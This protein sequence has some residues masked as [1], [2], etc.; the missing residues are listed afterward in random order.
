MLR[1][2]LLRIED[3]N[4]RGGKPLLA[5]HAWTNGPMMYLVYTAPPSDIT[6]GLVRDTRESIIDPVPWPDVDEAVRWYYYLDLDEGQPWAFFREPGEPDTIRWCG[7]PL[8]DDL[9]QR[10]SDIPDAYRYTSPPRTSSTTRDQGQ[11]QRVVNEPRRY[12]DPR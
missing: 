4:S 3:E 8:E 5:S 2:L 11:D 10:L 9:P 7:Y 1:N 12:A 6:W